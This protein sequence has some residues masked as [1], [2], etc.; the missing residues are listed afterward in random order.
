MKP[1]ACYLYPML[2]GSMAF[3]PMIGLL[4]LFSSS[5]FVVLAIAILEHSIAS[6][7]KYLYLVI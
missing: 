5:A 3:C 2:F 7:L 1:Q 6:W 4:F